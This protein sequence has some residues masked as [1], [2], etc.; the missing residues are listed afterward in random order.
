VPYTATDAQLN[1][2]KAYLLGNGT[3]GAAVS[4]APP[5]VKP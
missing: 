3:A 2:A 4:N 5:A 1:A